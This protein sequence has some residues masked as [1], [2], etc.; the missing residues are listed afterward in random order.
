MQ[1]KSVTKIANRLLK[2]GAGQIF[3]NYIINKNLIEEWRLNLSIA[4]Y[5]SI[6]KIL[7]SHLLSKNAKL[8]IHK[9]IISPLVLYGC[10]TLLN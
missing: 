8:S 6:Q 2:C 9:T 5:H 1:L 3:E 10:Q 7:P 4:C